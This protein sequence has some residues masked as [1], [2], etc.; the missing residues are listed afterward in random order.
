LYKS[1]NYS[2]SYYISKSRNDS[3]NKQKNIKKN[4]NFLDLDDLRDIISSIKNK[5]CTIIKNKEFNNLN[6]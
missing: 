5:R 4:T 2:Y 6:K 3:K 1:S